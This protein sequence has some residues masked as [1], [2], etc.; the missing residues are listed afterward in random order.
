MD[1]FYVI[2]VSA[3]VAIP[4]ALLGCW[5]LLRKMTMVGDA[6]SHAILPGIV[7][8]FLLTGSRNS[9]PM[10]VWACAFGLLT[11]FMIEWLHTKVR[12]QNDA[13]IG[14]TFTW[15]FAIGVILVSL[16]SSQV[17]LDQDCVLYGEIAYVPLD[18]W[19]T[20]SGWNLGPRAAWVM[21]AVTALVLLF[22]T[23]AYKELAI[24]TFDPAYAS[25][26]GFRTRV[27]HY[28]LMGLVSL[29][30]VTAFESVGAIL[31]VA[32]LVVPAAIAYLLVNS[33]PIMLMLSALVG[34]VIA[35][36]GYA[37][38]AVQQGSIAGAMATVSGVLLALAVL[39]SKLRNKQAAKVVEAQA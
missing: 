12:L 36:S 7:I 8:G 38:A 17:D 3:L 34:V 4:C 20:D 30:T 9:G 29:V 26:S 25:L 24:T 37:V 32:F 14:V 11:T 21:G 6:I 15:L 18:L 1:A 23:L 2:L 19:V 10:L 33:L 28:L 16:Y 31:V 13:A 39:V 27:W 35:V 5:L 22:T